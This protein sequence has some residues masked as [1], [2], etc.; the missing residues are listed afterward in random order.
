MERKIMEVLMK[1]QTMLSDHELSE[2]KDVM[3]MVFSGCTLK[4]LSEIPLA[5]ADG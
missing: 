2:L 5:L 4:I 3:N 1:M